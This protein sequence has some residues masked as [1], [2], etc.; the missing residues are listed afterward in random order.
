MTWIDTDLVRD[1]REDLSGFAGDLSRLPG[2]LGRTLTVEACAR[3]F[4]RGITRRSRR[5]FVPR[6]LAM[7]EILRPVILGPFGDLVLRRAA[8]RSVPKLEA[9]VRQLGRNFGRNSAAL[10]AG[11]TARTPDAAAGP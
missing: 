9:E 4:L 5:V 2:P 7:I 6:S 8:A 1:V 11:A 3:A 10:D